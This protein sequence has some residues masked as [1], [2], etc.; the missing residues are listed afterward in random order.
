MSEAIFKGA[1][2]KLHRFA[3]VDPNAEFPAAPAVYAFA[4]PQGRQWVPVFLSRTANLDAR[5]ARHPQW[6]D[7]RRLG[8]THVLIHRRGERDAR[9][10]VEADLLAALKPV[11]NGPFN[12]A[13]AMRGDNLVRLEPVTDLV[14]SWKT[15][16][17]G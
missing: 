1:S 10:G 8:A 15:R 6:A 13:R 7:A 3:V 11:M 5:M 4:R 16:S 17:V 14:Q 12:A 2:G 9:E